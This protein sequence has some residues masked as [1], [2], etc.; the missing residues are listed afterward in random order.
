MINL[1]A[2]TGSTDSAANGVIEILSDFG[3]PC[4]TTKTKRL[5]FSTKSLLAAIGGGKTIAFY[6][7]NHTV[8]AQGDPADA[9]YF[10]ERGRVRIS[11]LSQR[12]KEAVLAILGPGDFFGEGCLRGPPQRLMSAMTM[13]ECSIVRL[14][15]A[16]M[17]QALNDEPRLSEMFI[18]YLLHRVA[19]SEEDM[20]DQLLN[21]SEKRLARVLLQLASFGKNGKPEAIIPRISQETLAE[22]IGTTRSRVSSFMNKFR[23]LGL[24]DYNGEIH[25]HRSLASVVR[26]DQEPDGGDKNS[27][28]AG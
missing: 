17:A 26:G 13:T 22:M 16:A 21:S 6:T 23:R 8:F 1:A 11:V 19:R 28:M 3:G 2:A 24:I 9:V 15:R 14:E 4:M 5:T 20:I 7:A 25:V 10:I 27:R 18:S 12:G